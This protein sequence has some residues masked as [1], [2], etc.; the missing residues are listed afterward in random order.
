MRRWVVLVPLWRTTLGGW[1][2]IANGFAYVASGSTLYAFDAAGTTNCSGTPKT[3]SP[4][5]TA[6]GTGVA[7][8]PVVAGRFVYIVM[9]NKLYVFDGRGETGYTATTPKTC[10]PLWTA[11]GASDS[12]DPLPAVAGGRVFVGDQVY[13]AAGQQNCSGAPKTCGPLW[14]NHAFCSGNVFCSITHAV[15]SGGKVFYSATSSGPP[16][17]PTP[18][19]SR[20]GAFDAAGSAGCGGTPKVCEPLWYRDVSGSSSAPAVANGIVHISTSDFRTDTFEEHGAL[21]AFD[22]D[23]GAS[24]WNT[25]LGAEDEGLAIANGMLY[26]SRRGTIVEPSKSYFTAIDLSDRTVEQSVGYPTLIHPPIIANGV[27]YFSDSSGLH[28]LEVP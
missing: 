24:V 6:T 15:V 28:A 8:N 7:G 10:E 13:D 2:A 11:P 9:S 26:M 20:L 27:V 23:R 22:A 17:P 14:V 18:S 12:Y 5:W 16:F 1:T 3:C 19:T 4:V 25:L 21:Y